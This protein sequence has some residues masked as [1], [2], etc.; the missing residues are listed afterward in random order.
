MLGRAA[1][2]GKH[3]TGKTQIRG[4]CRGMVYLWPAGSHVV[5]NRGKDRQRRTP[6]PAHTAS[7]QVV[8][9]I[10]P[11]SCEA[12]WTGQCA[13]VLGREAAVFCTHHYTDCRGGASC[14]LGI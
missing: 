4:R 9:L 10:A 5:L 14:M 3:H 1:Q 11:S 12:N 7:C 8:K 2:D 13:S 6:L